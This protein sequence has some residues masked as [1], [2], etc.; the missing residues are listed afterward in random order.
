M[1]VLKSKYMENS[2]NY[3]YGVY[4]NFKGINEFIQ[5]KKTDIKKDIKMNP[6]HF[7]IISYLLQLWNDA[8]IKKY[9]ID[10]ENEWI[11]VTKPFIKSNLIILNISTNTETNIFTDL[12]NLGMIRKYLTI[13]R[14]RY[15]HIESEFINFL[16]Q[17]YLF[18]PLKKLQ[19]IKTWWAM[20]KK[21][22]G[23]HKDFEKWC[24]LF[25]AEYK[26]EKKQIKTNDLKQYFFDYLSECK[27]RAS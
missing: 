7:I 4:I 9:P 11:K 14:E 19:S 17:E 1:A 8:G 20:I 3:C 12:E 16:N 5:Y 27:R 18:N 10:S 24:M 25:D 6:T 23:K 21:E 26:I 22:F 13:D 15:F 2:S